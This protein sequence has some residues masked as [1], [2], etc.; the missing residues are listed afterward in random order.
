MD[1]DGPDTGAV[2]ERDPEESNEKPQDD[3]TKASSQLVS[4]KDENSL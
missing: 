2:S 3:Q 4:L 1:F